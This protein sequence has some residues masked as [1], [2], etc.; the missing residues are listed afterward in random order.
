[1]Y[2]YQAVQYFTFRQSVVARGL[3]AD[4]HEFEAALEEA[5]TYLMPRQLRNMFTTILI[6]GQPSNALSLW[7]HFKEHLSHQSMPSECA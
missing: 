4:D 6:Y 3:F 7:T 1:L 2:T 5:C